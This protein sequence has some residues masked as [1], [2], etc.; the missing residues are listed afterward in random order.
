[1][2]YQNFE[3]TNANNPISR[4]MVFICILYLIKIAKIH[5]HVHAPLQPLYPK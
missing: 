3:A 5:V 4:F 2:L 1:M